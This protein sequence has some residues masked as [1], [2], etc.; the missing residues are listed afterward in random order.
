LQYSAKMQGKQLLVAPAAHH[1]QTW[2]GRYPAFAVDYSGGDG[3]TGLAFCK[4][5]DIVT[6]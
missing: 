3:W 4:L 1:A 6:L 2:A 5:V